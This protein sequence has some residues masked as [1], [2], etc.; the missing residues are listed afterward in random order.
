[1]NLNQKEL[2]T[3]QAVQ[4]DT[5]REIAFVFYLTDSEDEE[6]LNPDGYTVKFNMLKPDNNFVMTTFT[7]GIIK[8]T[9]NMTA[10][11]GTG[12]YCIM[13][14]Q[15]DEVIYSGNGKIV[16]NDHV[17][18]AENID[19]V[20]EADGLVFPDDFYTRDTPIAEID[21]S[22]I[23][24]SS[25][26]S[27]EKI[28]E[29]IAAGTGADLIDDLTTSTEKTWSSSKISAGIAAK[30]SINDS[31]ATLNETWSGDKIATELAGKPDVDDTAMNY[32]DTWSSEKINS[33]IQSTTH[34][35]D[36]VIG[37][38]S[39]WSSQKIS[40]EISAITPGG[41]AYS[42][43]EHAIGTWID[44]STIYEKTY[45]Y[46]G[47]VAA[48]PF[49]TTIDMTGKNIIEIIPHYARYTYNNGQDY[50]ECVGSELWTQTTGIMDI[51]YYPGPYTLIV[52]SF[53][54]NSTDSYNIAFTLRYTKT[55]GN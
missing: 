49:Q 8:L 2:E 29:E 53:L 25:T 28:A 3:I 11:T 15:E 30:A 32:T 51:K 35:A 16:I 33:E 46:S 19:S 39:T 13:L 21:D 34:I 1:M 36:N 38:N 18:G 24:D 45:T 41:A 47:N 50:G 12:Y 55:G 42:T 48:N 31:S 27:S 44:G 20:S 43:T 26:W 10:V 4:S 37:N 52:S 22:G 23:S 6:P 5:L 14:M 17:I 54:G 40:N 7:E 9:L